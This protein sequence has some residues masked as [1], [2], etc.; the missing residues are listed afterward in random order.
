MPPGAMHAPGVRSSA[1]RREHPPTPGNPFHAN[2]GAR[3]AFTRDHCGSVVKRATRPRRDVE[4][5][6]R[7]LRTEINAPTNWSSVHLPKLRLQGRIQKRVF[8]A[9]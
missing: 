1:P 3:D 6:T 8:L 5:G 9:N 7:V 2:M 4:M